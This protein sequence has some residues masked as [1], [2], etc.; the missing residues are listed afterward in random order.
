LICC[1][2]SAPPRKNNFEIEK[3]FTLFFVICLFLKISPTSFSITLI[4]K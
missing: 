4:S 3:K 2:F 1:T